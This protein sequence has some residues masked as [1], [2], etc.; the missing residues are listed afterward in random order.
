MTR[1][2]SDRGVSSNTN[3]LARAMNQMDTA[4]T[5]LSAASIAGRE[6]AKLQATTTPP[7]TR[8][9]TVTSAG[10][11]KPGRDPDRSAPGSAPMP[12]AVTMNPKP[13]RPA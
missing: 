4:P 7:V 1:P 3:A 5:R 2:R 10:R 8:A 12:N 6:G 13:S 11:G 9:R